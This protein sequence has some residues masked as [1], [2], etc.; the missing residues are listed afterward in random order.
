MKKLFLTFILL[1]VFIVANAQCYKIASIERQ[2]SPDMKLLQVLEVEDRVLVYGSIT[3][4][5][6]KNWADAGRKT[7][8]VRNG[9]R[10]KLLNSVNLPFFDEAEPRHLVLLKDETVNFVLEFEKF[11]LSKSFDLLLIEGDSEPDKYDFY[12]IKLESINKEEVIDT[13]RFLDDVHTIYGKYVVNGKEHKYYIRDNVMFEFTNSWFGK[14]FLFEMTVVNSSNHGVMVDLD[15]IHASATDMKDR[16]KDVVRY[17][18]DSY[19]E[20]V[21]RDRQMAAYYNTGG[22]NTSDVNRHIDSESRKT[23]NVWTQIGLGALKALNNK[24]Q[25]NRV[26]QYL[27]KHPRTLPKGLRTTSLKPGES[28]SGYIPYKK[29]KNVKTFS[30]NIVLDDYTYD[31]KYQIND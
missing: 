9:M 11:D 21:E 27:K 30:L 16:P 20:Y 6:E 31:I 26:H 7:A 13:E 14:D 17:T 10:Y 19:D 5:K 18:P 8:I 23:N 25:A 29:I 4:T 1:C 3:T 28:I 22:S 24:S 12:G 15:K 2:S